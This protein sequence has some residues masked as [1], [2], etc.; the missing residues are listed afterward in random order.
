M[1]TGIV[2]AQGKIKRLSRQG[3]DLLIEIASPQLDFSDVRLGDSIATNGVCLTVNKLGDCRFSANVSEE[4]L[5]CSTL[6]SMEVGQVVN[7][8]KALT[9]QTRLGGHMVSGHVD[10]VG[11][12]LQVSDR[13]QSLYIEVEAPPALSKYIAHKGSISVDGI[14]LTVNGVDNNI[15]ELNIVPHTAAHTTVQQWQ[16]GSPVNLEVDLLA[17][18]IERLLQFE[19]NAETTQSQTTLDKR[20]L[21]QYGFLKG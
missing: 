8:E 7:L 12:I 18:H 17:R 6:A 4:T 13:G 1:F 9:L 16:A 14:S 19:Q 5:S 3:K 11:R 21:A 10:G 2:E 20:F 15:F